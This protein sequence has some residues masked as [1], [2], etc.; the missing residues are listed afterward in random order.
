MD[1]REVEYTSITV[2]DP[3]TVTDGLTQYTVYKVHTETTSAQ[4]KRGKSFHVHRRYKQ[5]VMLH[6][7]LKTFLASQT[8]TRCGDVP[9]L[10]GDTLASLLNIS[11]ARF[12]AEF[13]EDRRRGLEEFINTVANHT[14]LRFNPVLLDFLQEEDFELT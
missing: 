6:D 4:F 12:D 10:P 8:T 13:V 3:R 11:N 5:F 9:A 7:A 2:S 1:F 14:V